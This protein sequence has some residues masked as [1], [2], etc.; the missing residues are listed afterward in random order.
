MIYFILGL[1]AGGI[2]GILIICLLEISKLYDDK[3]D[4]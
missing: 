1:I 3:G 2:F 4:E